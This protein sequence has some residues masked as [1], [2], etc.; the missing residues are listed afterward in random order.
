MLK[1]TTV[2][3]VRSNN[4][5]PDDD[6][7]DLTETCWSCSNVN[8]NVSFKIIFRT[9]HLCISWLIIKLSNNTV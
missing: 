7:D 8:F 6:D 4:A 2:T 1:F 9:I 3:S 5:L